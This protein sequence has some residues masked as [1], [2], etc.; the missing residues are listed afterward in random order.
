[1]HADRLDPPPRALSPG[2]DYSAFALDPDGHCI[3]LYY[4][5]EQIGLGWPGAPRLRASRKVNGEGWP[6]VLPPLFGHLRRPGPSKARS[7][8]ASST[9][10]GETRAYLS[11]ALNA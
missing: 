4:Y 7:A 2:I 9:R 11:V 1:L 8:S 5:M 3:Q 6:E 10:P